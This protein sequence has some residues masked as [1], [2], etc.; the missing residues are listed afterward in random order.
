MSGKFAQLNKAVCLLKLRGG[1]NVMPEDSANSL[2]SNHERRLAV[3]CRHIDKLLADMESALSVSASKL[4]FPQYVPD[5]TSPQKRVIEDYISRIR[6]QLVRVLDGQN[7]ERPPADIPVSRTL[8][9]TLTFHL[10]RIAFTLRRPA[11]ARLLGRGFSESFVTKRPNGLIGDPLTRSLSAYHEL[12]YDWSERTLR[13]I[14]R[15]F[16]AFA[17]SYRA[18]VERSL[19]SQEPGPAQDEGMIRHDLEVLESAPAANTIAS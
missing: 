15:R 8:H 11:L 3:T 16:D 7:M 2:N 10:G 19:G 18:Q 5:L 1:C 13:Q 4:A 14:Q 12:L 9:V 17:N 6:A